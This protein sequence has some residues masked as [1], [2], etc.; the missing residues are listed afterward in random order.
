MTS[1][2]LHKLLNFYSVKFVVCAINIKMECIDA[3][4]S[5]SDIQMLAYPGDK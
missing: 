4:F 1:N 3:K 5:I 2:Y